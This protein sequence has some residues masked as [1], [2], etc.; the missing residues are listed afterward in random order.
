MTSNFLIMKQYKNAHKIKETFDISSLMFNGEIKFLF[1]FTLLTLFL[2]FQIITSEKKKPAL[3]L[4][5]YS[6]RVEKANSLKNIPSWRG[7]LKES[8]SPMKTNNIFDKDISASKDH[9]HAPN[10]EKKHTKYYREITI[11][12]I[13]LYS[14]TST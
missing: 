6:Y 11:Y 1:F 12:S 5:G 4:N 8:K 7:I 9:T 3:L 2:N 14:C 13:I 10:T